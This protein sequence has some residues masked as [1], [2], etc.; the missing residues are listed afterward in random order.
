MG[1]LTSMLLSLVSSPVTVW[2]DGVGRSEVQCSPSGGCGFGVEGAA[3]EEVLA[4]GGGC[5]VVRP[6]SSSASTSGDMVASSGELIVRVCCGLR[7]ASWMEESGL[8]RY[9]GSANGC[10]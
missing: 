9:G 5:V 2:P 1:G 3:A 6:A 8:A 4:G 10:G 7:W